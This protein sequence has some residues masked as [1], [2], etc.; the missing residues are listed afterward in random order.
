MS[1][2][3]TISSNLR[4]DLGSP[5]AQDGAVEID[6]L[7]PGQLRVE[8]GADL[9]Q[10]ADPPGDASATPAV[11][12]VIRERI[13]SSVLFPAPL[14]PMTRRPL[15]GH[16]NE[17]SESAAESSGPARS[18]RRPVSRPPAPSPAGRG[19]RRSVS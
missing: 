14:R 9:Q 3:A 18:S 15:P 6:V 16:L 7:A 12:S 5:H 4:R 1:A 10:R 13:F 19:A 2:K 8:P 11:G 17:T